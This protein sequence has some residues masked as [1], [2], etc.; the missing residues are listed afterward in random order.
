MSHDDASPDWL[1]EVAA[2][3]LPTAP[4]LHDAGLPAGPLAEIRLRLA[5]VSRG[6][7]WHPL[8]PGAE[9]AGCSTV[10][11]AAEQGRDVVAGETGLLD[12]ASLCRACTAQLTLPGRPGS[13]LAIARH[14]LAAQTW[15][16]KLEDAAPSV[17][18]SAYARWTARTP[19]TGDVVPAMIAA[20]DGDADWTAAGFA[21]AA[22]WQDLTRRAEASWAHA[23]Q[24]AGPPGLR[25]QAAAARALTGTRDDTITES[26]RIDAISAR[27]A[28]RSPSC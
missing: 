27:P 2:D 12:G 1:F 18:W 16:R 24:A 19:F 11:R 26:E 4:L 3:G 5:R 14:I 28:S 6:G 7:K 15:T 13:Y 17:D 22:A 21:A 23:R 9:A 10:R 8:L 20:L 25:E